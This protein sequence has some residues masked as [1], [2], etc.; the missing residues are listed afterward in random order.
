MHARDS[1]VS[2]FGQQHFG[3]DLQLE[4]DMLAELLAGLDT[5]VAVA[6]ATGRL[7][8]A[9]SRFVELLGIPNYLK[10]RG[11]S[12][13]DY[14]SARSWAEFDKALGEA[15]KRTV[16]GDVTVT[17]EGQARVVRLVFRKF[18][19]RDGVCIAASEV[20]E[21]VE[22]SKE[23]KR[24]QASIQSLSARILQVQD[25]ERRRL[26]RELHDQTGQ[27]IAALAMTLHQVSANSPDASPAARQAVTDSIA[28]VQKIE[29]QVRTLSYLLHPPLLDELGLRAAIDWF[30]AG[31]TQRSGIELACEIP[32]A[33][34][35][36][37]S[38]QETALFRVVQ[39]ALA[40]VLRHSDSKSAQIRVSYT[41]GRVQLAIEDKG[42][43]MDPAQLEAARQGLTPGVGLG[44]MRERLRELGGTLE[45]NSSAK[46]TQVIATLPV[47]A[48]AAAVETAEAPADAPGAPV[49]TEAAHEARKRVL[50]ADDHEVT[51]EGIRTLLSGQPDLEV[52]GEAADGVET[53]MKSEQLKPDL[54]VLD[55]AMPRL[56]GLG[57]LTEIRKSAVVPKVLVFTTHSFPGLSRTLR[58]AGCQGFVLKD[59]ASAELAR[60]VREVLRGQEFFAG[61]KP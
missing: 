20:T 10:L 49:S 13:K 22:T 34:P 37:S 18:A 9:N 61:D 58:A 36:F 47:E 21:L 60:G 27:E 31:F 39:G 50:I 35:R 54:I 12:L 28:I 2:G 3:R 57:V 4:P 46:G 16:R 6:S 14:I 42:K 24:T 11:L 48:T 43:G 26:A 51:R 15:E 44:G 25:E 52:C 1:K 23:L 56:G 8:Y 7:S 19:R 32:E 41:G 53:L 59:R 45:I 5:G 30:V 29:R 38:L 17:R 33:L 55:L 40:N